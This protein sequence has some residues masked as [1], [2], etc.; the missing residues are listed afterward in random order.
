MYGKRLSGIIL[1]GSYARKDFDAESDIDFLVLLNQKQFDYAQ[2]IRRITQ[3]TYPMMLEHDIIIS[4]LPS[5]WI[6]GVPNP[7][8]SSIRLKKTE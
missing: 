5:P 8:S 3:V 7:A 6:A 4:C 2:E 1:Y